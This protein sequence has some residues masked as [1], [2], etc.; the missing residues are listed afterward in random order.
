M[1]PDRSPVRTSPQPSWQPLDRD[2]GRRDAD[3]RPARDRFGNK[4]AISGF[5]MTE[6][7]IPVWA[8]SAAR[9]L[10]LSAGC[11]RTSSRSSSLIRRPIRH[12]AVEASGYFWSDSP[13]RLGGRCPKHP[14]AEAQPDQA[15]LDDRICFYLPISPTTSTPAESSVT[16]VEPQ[17]CE[18]QCSRLWP[19]QPCARPLLRLRPLRNRVMATRSAAVSSPRGFALPATLSIVRRPVRCGQTFQ[20]FRLSLGGQ[21]RPQNI[22]RERSSFHIRRCRASR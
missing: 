20:A 7:N 14:E 11:I 12:W 13:A 9:A 17:R 3:L 22:S 16:D 6:V 21:R 1:G 19:L 2:D 18:R 8:A 15:A 10:M 5:G 4:D